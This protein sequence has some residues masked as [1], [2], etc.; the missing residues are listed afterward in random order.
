MRDVWTVF[1][2][3]LKELLRLHGSGKRTLLLTLLPLGAVGVLFATTWNKQL[4][5]SPAGAVF[6]VVIPLG[7]VIAVICDSFAGERERHTLETLLA[8]RLPNN[9][10]LFGKMG[11]AMAF[12]WILTL[13]IM[14]FMRS[15][16]LVAKGPPESWGYLL[17]W[18]AGA[19]VFAFPIW[20]LWASLGVLVSLRS[21]TVKRAQQMLSISF[22]LVCFLPAIVVGGSRAMQRRI[23]GAARDFQDVNPMTVALVALGILLL[24][25][26]V[27]ILIAM[28][29]FKRSKLIL[30]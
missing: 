19:L 15:V 13:L 9:A 29:R 26:V 6:C 22:L 12:G 30:D 27:L 11:A 20:S 3:E 28:A 17:S 21:P 2:K 16:S 5:E 14:V 4:L 8:S 7:M 18:H 24:V 10:I 25:D 23:E 1:K